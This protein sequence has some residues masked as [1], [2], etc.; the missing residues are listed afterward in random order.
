MKGLGTREPCQKIHFIFGAKKWNFWLLL[1][2]R[3]IFAIFET[4]SKSSCQKQSRNFKW[5][6]A[7]LEGFIIFLKFSQLIIKVHVEHNL[8]MKFQKIWSSFSRFL[9]FLK[10]FSEKSKIRKTEFFRGSVDPLRL[11]R[12]TSN[13]NSRRKISF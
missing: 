2:K 6:E 5:F 10:I 3:K 8:N 12:S 13:F 1:G 7:H 9:N 11:F 4:D